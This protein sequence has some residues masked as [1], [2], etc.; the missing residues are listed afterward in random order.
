MSVINDIEK[1]LE[2]AKNDGDYWEK[3]VPVK[4]S[5]MNVELNE[6]VDSFSV[7]R[8]EDKTAVHDSISNHVAWSLLAFAENM[9]TYSLRLNEQRFFTN[10]LSALGMV[11]GILD[12][13]EI[14]LIM[15]LYYDVSIRCNL[16]FSAVLNQKDEFAAFVK[17]FLDRDE[18]NKT[19]KCMGYIFSED[20]NNYPIY[21]RTW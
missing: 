4:M 17:A 7:L 14:L 8:G 10:G 9:A 21:R 11:M 2:D 1:I 16:S 12:T 3:K 19:L 18:V 5:K 20:D 6:V 13:R 15:P